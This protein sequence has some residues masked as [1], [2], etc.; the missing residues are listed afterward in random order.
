MGKTSE[1][2][3][4]SGHVMLDVAGLELTAEDVGRLQHPAC[5]GVILFTR[6]YADP[7]Q[8]TAL[9]GSIRAVSP[10]PL[11]IAVDHE[12]GRVQR[13]REGFTR[14]PPMA[15]LGRCYQ[16]D[17]E[18]ALRRARELGWLMAVE[19]RMADIDFSF[20]PVLDLDLGVCEVIGDRAFHADPDVIAAL[21][22][23]WMQGM[24]DAGMA[25][26][27]KH[28]PG[29][30][31]VVEDSHLDLPVDKRDIETILATDVRPYVCLFRD[32]LEGVMPAHVIYQQADEHA[33]G[34]SRFWL[35]QI[36]REQLGFDG[37]IFSDDL[38]M[39][40]A[41]SA[42][43]YARRAQAAMDA[44]CDMVLICNQPQ[45]ADEV[46]QALHGY[47]AAASLRRLQT[48]AARPVHELAG[49]LSGKRRDNAVALAADG[50]AAMEQSA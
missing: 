26:V 27:G 20:A 35:Q 30:G 2:V 36:L 41:E 12:G 13:F 3:G 28:F 44:G 39:A 10:T 33:A 24:H 46:L 11:L 6:N 7:A 32:G 42:G 16:E 4:I 5:G 15:W 23:A 34:F 17:S 19:C 45:A 38:S 21:A 43:S 40:A 29:H 49:Q 14:L 48:M 50:V 31:A 9:V 47:Q 18:E 1:A 37:V 22:G 8:L 25:A